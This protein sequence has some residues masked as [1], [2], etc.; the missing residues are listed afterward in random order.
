MTHTKNTDARE[1]DEINVRSRVVKQFV[2][3]FLTAWL[4]IQY[5]RYLHSRQ[6]SRT[7]SPSLIV[8]ESP[9]C[10]K[11]L[12]NVLYVRPHGCVHDLLSDVGIMFRSLSYM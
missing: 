4:V 11:C 1:F 3:C 5:H 10:I 6:V 8:R 9:V 7:A 12:L 2:P